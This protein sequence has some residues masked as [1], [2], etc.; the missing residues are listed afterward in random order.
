MK[1]KHEI[2]RGII[3]SATDKWGMQLTSLL[4]FVLLSR[5][6]D[7][8][9]FGLVALATVF[10]SFVRVFLDRGFSDAI[11]QRRDLLKGHLDT[12]FWLGIGF[13]AAMTLAG[14]LASDLAAAL[15]S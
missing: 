8:E 2:A 3:W 4:I 6:L 1:L 10:T 13:G 7:P 12:A 5:L 11:I 15:L 9:A 14:I